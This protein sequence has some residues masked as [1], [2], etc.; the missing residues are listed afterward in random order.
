VTVFDVEHCRHRNFTPFAVDVKHVH[1]LQKYAVP[2][3][4][5][6]AQMQLQV[7]G[8]LKQLTEVPAKYLA[9]AMGV[10]L[11]HAMEFPVFAEQGYYLFHIQFI[12]RYDHF[13]NY[14]KGARHHWYFLRSGKNAGDFY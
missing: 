13:V 2:R 12:P 4:G 6:I 3:H 7:S 14:S 1:A 9:S 10:T 8:S 5:N 11:H